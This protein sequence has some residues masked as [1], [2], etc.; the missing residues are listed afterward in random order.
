M[1]HL[2][3]LN[4]DGSVPASPSMSA[5]T[6]QSALANGRGADDERSHSQPKD[7]ASVSKP[8]LTHLMTSPLSGASPW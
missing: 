1:R 2:P 4:A 7:A 3:G 8:S 6:A 5:L